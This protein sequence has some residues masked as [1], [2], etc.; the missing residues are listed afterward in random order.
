MLQS[1]KQFLTELVK[2]TIITQENA[3][4]YEIESLQQNK[5][6]EEFL[7]TKPEIS[8]S[9]ILKVKARILNVPYIDI[10]SAAIDPH[11]LSLVPET[12]S[13]KYSIMPYS[14]DPT[15]DSISIATSDPLNF[16]VTDFLEKKTG[17]KV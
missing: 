3:D 15:K 4:K 6:I 9:A 8:R 13:R 16:N 14:Y 1:P 11:A 12:V 7:L 17:K 5:P 10:I 2:D